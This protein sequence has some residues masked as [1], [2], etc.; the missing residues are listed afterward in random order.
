MAT[1]MRVTVTPDYTQFE[2]EYSGSKKGKIVVEK[3]SALV[4]LGILFENADNSRFFRT[5]IVQDAT[6]TNQIL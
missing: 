4:F 2:W 1:V 6:C 5:I 3:N